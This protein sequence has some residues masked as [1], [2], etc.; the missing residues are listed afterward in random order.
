MFRMGVVLW[1]PDEVLSDVHVKQVVSLYRH[2]SHL[3]CV[4]Q[5]ALIPAG[6]RDF[7][8]LYIM[9]TGSRVHSAS[10]SMVLGF[11][12][13]VNLPR[14]HGDRLPPSSDEVNKWSKTSTVPMSVRGMNRYNILRCSRRWLLSS[15]ITTQK[16]TLF[17]SVWPTRNPSRSFGLN[18]CRWLN[19]R[20]NLSLV[21]Y[22]CHWGEDI[23]KLDIE[24][25]VDW[26]ELSHGRA[27][28]WLLIDRE[29]LY[30][31]LL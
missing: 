9:Q 20:Y 21:I 12:P 11:F 10:C 15:S 18:T 19:D 27:Q 29:F 7:S 22:S 17:V 23:M 2:K 8:L 14:R 25:Y 28:S 3:I 4:R 16:A 30:L 1:K 31:Q 26:I 6:A 24:G 13:R 5:E